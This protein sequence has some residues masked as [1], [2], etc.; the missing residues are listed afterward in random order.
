MRF[1]TNFHALRP[2]VAR[3]LIRLR[4]EMISVF[5]PAK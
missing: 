3:Y 2:E 1:A 5:M 4:A